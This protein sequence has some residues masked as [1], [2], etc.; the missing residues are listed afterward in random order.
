MLP[1]PNDAVLALE[2]QLGGRRPSGG[3]T[4]ATWIIQPRGAVQQQG[5]MQECRNMAFLAKKGDICI[6]G[7]IGRKWVSRLTVYLALGDPLPT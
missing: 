4:V 6:M 3:G 5:R 7:Q 1:S 2:S